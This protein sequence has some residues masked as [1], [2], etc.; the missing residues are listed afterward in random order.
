MSEI[1]PL[2]SVIRNSNLTSKSPLL[3]LLHGYG[4]DENDLF[5]FANEMPKELLIISL[6]APHKI[7]PYGYA[8]YAINFDANQKK[9]N[10]LE[11][12]KDAMKSIN[13]CIETA[14]SLYSINNSNIS[15]LGFSQGCILSL[16]LALN[17]PKKF[18]N[19][20]GLGGYICE[21]FLNQNYQKEKHKHLDF[22]CSHGSSDQV[23][24]VEWARKTP[25]F[26]KKL[27]IKCKYSE[28][29]TGHGITPQ[30]FFE[31]KEWLKVRI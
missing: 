18:K 25:K 30:N 9:W 12:A 16:A 4:S 8:W 7:N 13:K 5:I 26:L 23:I 10:N 21:D 20:I 31:F 3:I 11:Q 24:P 17:Y 6:R 14:C 19:I 27:K 28:F 15:I 29:P 1:L 2:V 22:Y